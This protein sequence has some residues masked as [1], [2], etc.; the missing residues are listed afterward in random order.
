MNWCCAD[1]PLPWY[2]TAAR[3]PMIRTICDWNASETRGCNPLSSTPGEV[4][5][6]GRMNA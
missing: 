1:D 3:L 5:E 6:K 2:D 4:M